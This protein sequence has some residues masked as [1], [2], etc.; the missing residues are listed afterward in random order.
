MDEKANL[1]NV[2]LNYDYLFNA[3]NNFTPYVSA[4][5]GQSKLDIDTF[6]DTAMSYGAQLGLLYSLTKNIEFEAGTS[7]TKLDLKPTTPTVSGSY[8]DATLMNASLYLQAD[9]MTRLYAGFNYKF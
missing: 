7:Y 9:D 8:Y 6:D 1:T 3:V 4:H 2:T 5:L